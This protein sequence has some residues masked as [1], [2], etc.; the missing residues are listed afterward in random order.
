MGVWYSPLQRSWKSEKGSRSGSLGPLSHVQG[1]TPVMHE[2]SGSNLAEAGEAVTVRPLC[3]L[4]ESNV[5]YLLWLSG[6]VDGNCRDQSYS[7]SHPGGCLVVTPV[8]NRLGAQW[9]GHYHVSSVTEGLQLRVAKPLY[10]V[11]QQQLEALS[12]PSSHSRACLPSALLLQFSGLPS[13]C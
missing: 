2:G 8:T 3:V 11:T 13:A 5:C 12:V 9:Q 1:C 7:P 10:K 6:G 4:A